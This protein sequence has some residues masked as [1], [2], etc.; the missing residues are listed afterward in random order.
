MIFN[1]AWYLNGYHVSD[2]M[3]FRELQWM[4]DRLKTQLEK[5]NN[6]NSGMDNMFKNIPKH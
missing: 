3:L 5:E 6:K 2:N 1:L 4:Y